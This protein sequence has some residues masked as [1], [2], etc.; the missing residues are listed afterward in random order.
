[1]SQSASHSDGKHVQSSV[2]WHVSFINVLPPP[3]PHCQEHPSTPY[4]IPACGHVTAWGWSFTFQSGSARLVPDG[5]RLTDPT[6]GFAGR[7]PQQSNSISFL[8]SSCYVSRRTW[9]ELVFSAGRSA[10]CRESGRVQPLTRHAKLRDECPSCCVTLERCR[11]FLTRGAGSQARCRADTT[12]SAKGANARP[13]HQQMVE[14][15]VGKRRN[16][17]LSLP[18]VFFS[19]SLVL[20]LFCLSFKFVHSFPCPLGALL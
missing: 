8:S 9:S 19:F 15:F 7:Y 3:L 11:F 6:T 14:L 18:G 2:D 1:M 4:T 10:T 16:S 13:V 5:P 20:P 12:H 17:R